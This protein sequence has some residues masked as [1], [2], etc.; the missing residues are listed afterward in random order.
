MSKVIS[1]VAAGLFALLGAASAPTATSSLSAAPCDL[2]ASPTGNDGNSGTT[3]A[4]A[5]QS[6]IVL[7]NSL[8]A[9]QTGC[10]EDNANFV[11]GGGDAITS[12][13]GTNGNPKILRPTTPGQRAT[14]TTTTG[15]WIQAAAHDLTLVDL[16]IRRLS[17]TG[18]G[19]LFLI[20]GDRITLDGIDATYPDNICLDIGEDPRVAGTNSA[21]D[22]VLRRSRIHD[23]GSNYGPPHFQND[24][25]VHGIYAEYLRDGPDADHYSAII[26][27]NLIYRNHNRGLQLYPD[28]DDALIQFNVFDQNGANLN[29]GSQPDKNVYS[30]R[31]LI[32]NNILTDSVLDGLQP[33]GF[34][35]DTSEVLGNLPQGQNF[36]NV[37]TGNCI[38][39]VAHPDRLYEGYGFTESQN[40]ENQPP[41]YANRAA[42]DFTLQ[43]GD[44]CYGKG[45]RPAATCQ[46]VAATIAG[47]SGSDTLNGTAGN[48]VIAGLD[49]DDT[50]NGLGGDD[51]L[52]GG[53]G[54]DVIRPGT[55]NDTAV[56]GGNGTDT[57][58]YDTHPA[59]VVVNLT[60]GDMYVPTDPNEYDT[61]TGF[62][63]ATGSSY[64]DTLIGNGGPNKLVGGPGLDALYGY[65]GDDT[66]DAADGTAGETVDCGD[67][68]DSARADAGDNV[69]ANCET[70]TYPGPTAVRLMRFRALRT[71]ST[72]R[73][74]WSMGSQ[75]G[76]A[77][78]EV[79]GVGRV[80][81]RGTG[82]ATYVLV[83]RSPRG[84]ST[85]E[86]RA[87][88][89]AGRVTLASARPSSGG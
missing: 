47:T 89:A 46:N 38:S 77:G 43:P 64:G 53:E 66:L 22:F 73:L 56:D 87:L 67:G 63:S 11:L 17:G 50:I 3:P 76:V 75:V 69:A 51:K 71:G 49:G 27:D 29:I 74:S 85:Y 80:R 31:N 2:Y 20:D 81:A 26:E 1:I 10:L 40:I 62:E 18:S 88:T 12:T 57:I 32:Q 58:S 8:A 30:E 41:Q 6:P 19:S 4:Q 42:G 33:G 44:P 65:G 82:A 86:L 15:F 83:D 79:Q 14:I 9:G 68:A 78:Y 61:F 72:V 70:V 54:N 23:C 21:E 84:G 52:C 13:A 55:G 39:N 28:D 45:P 25:G 5:K 59:G 48:D 34:V 37:V 7:L 16:N 35:G 36:G 60:N 24:S